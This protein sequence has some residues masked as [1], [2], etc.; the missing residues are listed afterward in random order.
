M[1]FF[2]RSFLGDVRDEK[3]FGLVTGILLA[4]YGIGATLMLLKVNPKIGQD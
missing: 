4:I 3:Q 1:A 2:S